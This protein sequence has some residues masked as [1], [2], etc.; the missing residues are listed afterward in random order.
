MILPLI[1]HLF[2]R[3]RPAHVA[4]FVVSP[5]IDTID[6][7]LRARSWADVQEK[8]WKIVQPFWRN[9]HPLRAAVLVADVVR[10]VAA[11]LHQRPRSILWRPLAAACATVNQLGS[12]RLN[13]CVVAS[14]RSCVP[15]SQVATPYCRLCSTITATIPTALLVATSRIQTYY[16]ETTKTSSDELNG[17]HG[18]FYAVA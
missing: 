16:E 6:G 2:S 13:I 15:S 11:T 5:R 18:D 1:S 12:L 14:A 4:G 3:R 8:S 7:V 17:S 9:D 10:V